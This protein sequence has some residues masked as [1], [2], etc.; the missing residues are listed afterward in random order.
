MSNLQDVFIKLM[1]EDIEGQMSIDEKGLPELEH[2]YYMK[3]RGDGRL[4]ISSSHPYDLT[5]YCFA[6]S[7]DMDPNG[8]WQIID[9]GKIVDAFIGWDKTVER[10]KEID[11]T[12]ERRID[13]T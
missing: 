9:D 2:P 5:D 13:R 11:S 6:I 10:M 8:S 4:G 3:D 12:K 7:Q 1:T